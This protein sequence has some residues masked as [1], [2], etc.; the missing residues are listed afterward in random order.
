MAFRLLNWMNWIFWLGTVALI[1]IA[2]T[3]CDEA[4]IGEYRSEYSY[5]VASEQYLSI[6]R[7]G[8]N[9]PEVSL[10]KQRPYRRAP[11]PLAL[12]SQPASGLR[13]LA[14]SSGWGTSAVLHLRLLCNDC[15]DLALVLRDDGEAPAQIGQPAI[16]KGADLVGSNVEHLQYRRMKFRN[17]LIST[18]ASRVSERHEDYTLP[19][20]HSRDAAHTRRARSGLN[21]A[22]DPTRDW[23]C[24]VLFW[25]PR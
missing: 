18:E 1:L 21:F 23:K 20:R 24:G 3:G 2:V 9:L 8:S 5:R 12:F 4:K 15:S 6:G 17:S 25:L 10:L 19:T 13:A 14:H 7:L 11:P 16:I 22:P